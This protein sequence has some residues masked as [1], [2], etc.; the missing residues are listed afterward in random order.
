MKYILP[1]SLVLL[2][3][4][5]CQSQPE[6]PT[7][8]AMDSQQL[9][10]LYSGNSFTWH[11]KGSSGPTNY[12]ADKTAAVEYKSKKSDGK[13]SVKNDMLCVSWVEFRAGKERCSTVYDMGDGEYHH[14]REGKLSFI[15]KLN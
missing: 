7:I 1:V 2:T 8:P 6:K 9:E 15:H 11:Q 14:Y 4:T 12:N 13:W 10:Q 5:G 3:L